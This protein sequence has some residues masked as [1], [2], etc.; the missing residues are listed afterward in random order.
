MG[1]IELESKRR[2]KRNEIRTIILQTIRLTGVLGVA[3]IAPNVLTAMVRTGLILSP[4]HREL[5]KRS[6]DRLY[7]QGLLKHGNDGLRLT[8]KGEQTLQNLK[9]RTFPDKKNQRWDR[10]WRML[11]FDI[12]EKRSALRAGIRR[13]LISN[14]FVRLQNSV[15]VYPYDCEDWLNLWKADLKVGRELL[16]L[17]VDSIEGE[18]HLKRRFKLP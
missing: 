4:R 14:G 3:L 8:E 5:V 7:A 17:I 2:A 9:R 1:E 10:K 6:V 18:L 16:Y 12:P 13:T 15:W 11:I